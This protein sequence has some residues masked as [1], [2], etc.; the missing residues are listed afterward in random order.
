MVDD[1]GASAAEA[2]D[3]GHGVL[4]VGADEVNVINLKAHAVAADSLAESLRSR[5]S[6][7]FGPI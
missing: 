7:T 4:H 3:R 1:E 6:G 2:S 5:Q